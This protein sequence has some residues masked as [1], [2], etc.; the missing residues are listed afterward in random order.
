M[1]AIGILIISFAMVLISLGLG[2]VSCG[3]QDRAGPI[4]LGSLAV[5]YPSAV[6]FFAT[7]G[8]MNGG[9]SMAGNVATVCLYSTAAL[10]TS[11]GIKIVL[12]N[13]NKPKH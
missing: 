3:V 6:V 4:L 2:V 13:N 8:Y 5:A 1:I 11:I 9:W 7:I 10:G 12:D